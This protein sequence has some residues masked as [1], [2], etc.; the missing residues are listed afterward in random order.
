VISKSSETS[1]VPSVEVSFPVSFLVSYREPV[2]ALQPIRNI[3]AA[4]IPMNNFNLNPKIVL[5]SVLI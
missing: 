5:I 3:V 4:T 2:E 1:F